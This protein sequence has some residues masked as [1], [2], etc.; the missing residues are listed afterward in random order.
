MLDF[1]LAVAQIMGNLPLH[2]LQDTMFASV[3][4]PQINVLASEAA[5]IQEDIEE[6]SAR[7]ASLEMLLVTLESE[8][9]TLLRE[10]ATPAMDAL[11]SLVRRIESLHQATQDRKTSALMAYRD[12]TLALVEIQAYAPFLNACKSQSRVVFAH[13]Q[14]LNEKARGL[15]QRFTELTTDFTFEISAAQERIEKLQNMM[16]LAATLRDGVESQRTIW[17]EQQQIAEAHI[18]EARGTIRSAESKRD[19]TE[20]ARVVRN[21]L[22]FGLGEIFDIFDLNEEIEEAQRTVARA[23]QNVRECEQSILRA[24]AAVQQINDQ[25]EL[26]DTLGATVHTQ[27][28]TLQASVTHRQEIRTRTID[29][30]NASL[31]VSLFVGTLAAKSETLA[32]HHTAQEFARSVLAFGSLVVSEERF[33]E[34]LLQHDP[35]ALQET[36]GMIARSDGDYV[37]ESGNF[38]VTQRPSLAIDEL[39]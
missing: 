19:S 6:A 8:S 26:L 23:E 20:S 4:D 39:M 25:V 2:H 1:V 36:L 35:E 32:V 11:L 7:C 10:D 12:P 5:G 33:N 31:D 22:T 18:Q 29:L 38:T 3:E 14:S 27:D 30:A 13:F 9:A 24:I 17:H 28:L 34:L 21:I 37:T 16:R 15:T